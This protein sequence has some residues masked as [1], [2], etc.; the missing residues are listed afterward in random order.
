MAKTRKRTASVSELINT[1]FKIMNFDGIWADLFGKPQKTGSWIIWG[2]ASNGKTAFSIQLCKYLTNFDR[3]GY[4]S[5][6]EGI[7]ESLKL[8]C[9]RENMLEVGSRFQVI[10]KEPIDELENRLL[11]HKSPG[12]IVIDSAQYIDMKV[13]EV[14]AFLDRHKNKL[15]IFVSHA[16]GKHPEGTLAKKIRFHSSVKIHIEGYRAFI[17][18]R[19][20]GD[21]SKHY[22]IWHEGAS[23]YWGEEF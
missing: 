3:V 12:I 5:I 14:K 2:D 15:F 10:D 19:Y 7:S 13:R 22:T 11:R 9:I 4:N 18:S 17:Q 1:K 8:S 20:G 23:D 21:K 16:E 6:E